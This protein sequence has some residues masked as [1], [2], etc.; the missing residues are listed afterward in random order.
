MG[1]MC[2]GE[3]KGLLGKRGLEEKCRS[4]NAKGLFLRPYL[5]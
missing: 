5:G 3:Q 1:R 4:R 2:V